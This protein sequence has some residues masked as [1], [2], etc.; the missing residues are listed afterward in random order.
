MSYLSSLPSEAPFD[1]SD[2]I[3][4]VNSYADLDNYAEE[5]TFNE[6]FY[7][8][9][10]AEV[11]EH[12]CAYCGIH[13]TD[14]V[15]KCN[16]CKKWFCN[17][18]SSGTGSHIVNHL[19]MAKHNVISLHEES[20]L[21]DTTLECYNCGNKNVF[22]LG[23]VSAKVDSVVVIL[24]RLPCAQI[25]DAN[26]DT[27][28]W[29]SLIEDR[30]LL[31]WVAAQPDEEQSIDAR[32]I[33]PAQIAKLE[34][35]WRSN[36]DAT[37][38]DV[39]K[40]E[41]EEEEIEPILMRYGD[42]FQYQRSFAPLVKIEA[43]HD[44]QLK[45]S[46][47]LEHISVTWGL[48]LNN[49]HL[50]SFT[51]SSFVPSEV[52]VAVGDEIIL[53]YSGSEL[54]KPWEQ[55]GYIIRLPGHLQEDYTLE[56]NPSKIAPPIHLTTRFTAEFVWKGTSY[57]RQQEAMKT[58]A[59]NEQS[60][61]A[62]IYHKLLGLDAPPVEFDVKLPKMF[63]IPELAELNVSQANAVG[64]VLQRPLSLIQ[65]PPG[66]GK[67]VTSATIVYHLSKINKEQILVCAPSNV[68]VDHLA[69]KLDTLGLKVVRITAR[70]REDVETS[71]RKLALHERVKAVAK[72]RL[73]KLIKLKEEVGELSAEDTKKYIAGVKKAEK[74]ILKECDVI[75]C[76]LVGA[77]DRRLAGMQFRTVLI[78][79]S[80]QAS[81]PECLIPIVKGARQVILVGDHQQLGPVILNKRAGDAGLR[82]S[83]FER[84]ILLGHIPIRLE[85]QYRM[86]PCLSEFPSNVFY[87]GMLQ[88]G[89]TAE[90]R[91]D[92]DSSFPWPIRETPMMFWAVYGREEISYSGVSYLNRVEAMNCERIISKL[93]RD[94]VQP[95]QIGVITP[96]EGQ[97]AY[98]VQYMQ[99]NGTM[100][101]KQMY[102][103]VEVASVDAFQGREKDYIVLSC[104]R[105][106]DQQVIG[107]LSDP[108][109]LNVALTR[110]KYGLFVLGNPKALSRNALWNRLLVH[111]REKGCLVEGHLDSLQLSSV[112]L[113]RVFNK[114]S[115]DH[116]RGNKNGGVGSLVSSYSS[117]M[118]SSRASDSA[119]LVSYDG[120]SMSFP[121]RNNQWPKLGHGLRNSGD[122]SSMYSAFDSVAGSTASTMKNNVENDDSAA[123]RQLT[124]SFTSQFKF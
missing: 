95:E 45:E 14:C 16:T 8:H 15:V 63:S 82:Q 23:F 54:D 59:V 44:K 121:H 71:V 18:K 64:A 32:L 4:L 48:G 65:G 85:V 49:R 114:H 69:L 12:A 93:F 68:A 115:N 106:N 20:D 104:V 9:V 5:H 43:D 113:S 1:T 83:L 11:P 57:E 7:P 79:E 110:A 86:H 105:A 21:G 72:G 56:L 75:C 30:Q 51:F 74:S 97:R 55:A 111:F 2:T 98:V 77:G 92:Y 53:R 37:L 117:S 24:C 28:Q 25:K 13:A 38:E 99:S 123:I 103:D 6:S 70:S 118:A 87:D 102:M 101:D 10:P 29:Q 88:N 17:T 62:H 35:K 107:F 78:D 120:G 41:Q 27:E 91:T 90:S 80:T 33:T 26:W 73:S 22:V 34:A 36:A 122:T 46:Q 109:R 67:T 3:S 76:T 66:T 94:G 42:A 89:I 96:Y 47:G 40:P 31:P 58:F 100:P 81:E 116:Q 61:S 119:S 60:V 84:L 52:K 39:E 50:A 124:S 112:Q 108:R 19:V